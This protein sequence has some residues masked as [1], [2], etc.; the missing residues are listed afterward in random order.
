MVSIRTLE[1]VGP[2]AHVTSWPIMCLAYAIGM[3][4]AA[5]GF[6]LLL[7]Q[8]ADYRLFF[9]IVEAIMLLFIAF[10]LSSYLWIER[11]SSVLH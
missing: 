7:D 1:L 2:T 9:W 3:G 5:T 6:A 4:I 8:G 10:A 11:K